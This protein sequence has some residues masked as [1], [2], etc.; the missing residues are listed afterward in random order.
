MK[1]TFDPGRRVIWATC[2]SI[3][4]HPSRAIQL[5]IFWLTTRTGH[6]LSGLDRG[7]SSVIGHGLRSQGSA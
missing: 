6:G 7:V 5:P 2:P 4:I 1:T 3:Q